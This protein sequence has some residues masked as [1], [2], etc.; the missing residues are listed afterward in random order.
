MPLPHNRRM[1]VT[2]PAESGAGDEVIRDLAWWAK[3]WAK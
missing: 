2:D 3:K 1:F